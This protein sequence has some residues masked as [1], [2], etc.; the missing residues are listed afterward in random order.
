MKIAQIA[1]LIER[2]PPKTYGGTERVVS[3]L[4]EELV[5]R[6]HDVTLFASGDSLTG[7]RLVPIYPT[8][9]RQAKLDD[10]Q[11]NSIRLMGIGIPYQRQDEFDI[12]HDHNLP[13]S[14]PTAN[15]AKTPVV[16]TLHGPIDPGNQELYENLNNPYLVSISDAQVPKNSV[17]NH[18]ATIYHG[19]NMQHYPFSEISED[20]LLYVGRIAPKKGLHHEIAVAQMLNKK[21]II[22]AKLDKIHK[23]YFEQK[24][25]SQLNDQIRWIGEVT[26]TERN[27]L[28][29]HALAFIHPACWEEPFG[30]TMIESMACGTPVVAFKRGSIP[31]LIKN[32][33]NGF[34]VKTNQE[35]AEAIKNINKIDRKF[36][37][38]YALQNFNVEKMT[39]EYEMVYQ[40][41]L[42]KSIKTQKKTSK[43]DMY[44]NILSMQRKIIPR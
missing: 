5:K 9:L 1:P 15:L 35:M 20:Y 36:C 2:V 41:I 13:F 6:G 43:T 24:I 34:I 44:Q 14:I 31:E 4:T 25:K 16:A 18:V 33:K 10:F 28:M 39:D 21:L 29:T 23:P 17:I 30:L 11:I 42:Q 8:H 27:R 32:G 38:K 40:A 7:A 26:E 37:R 19:F 12:I 3:A 22:A